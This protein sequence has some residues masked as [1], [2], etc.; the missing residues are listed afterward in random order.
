MTVNSLFCPITKQQLTHSS[1]EMLD[2]LNALIHLKQIEYRGGGM[3]TESFD[4]LLVEPQIKIGYAIK[5][6]IP[7]LIPLLAVSLEGLNIGKS[8]D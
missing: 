4:G 8:F 6:G 7:Q 5:N 2:A 3:V 1:H